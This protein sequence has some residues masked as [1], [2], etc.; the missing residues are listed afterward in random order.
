MCRKIDSRKYLIFFFMLIGLMLV[1]LP[2]YAEGD[3]W[4]PWD[5]NEIYEKGTSEAQVPAEEHGFFKKVMTFP[6]QLFITF[7]QK[8]ISPVDGATC[9]FYPTCSAYAKHALEKH[10]LVIGLAMAN[11]R[12]NRYH[13]PEGYELIYKFDRYYIYD[14][15]ENNDFWFARGKD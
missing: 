9:D 11:E 7:F 5:K 12:T 13:S 2:F 6:P 3:E 8:V 14:P 1:S 4:G 15:V 10:G